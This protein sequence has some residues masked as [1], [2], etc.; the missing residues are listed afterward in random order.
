MCLQTNYL[1]ACGH[2]GGFDF[3]P[4]SRRDPPHRPA[5][6]CAILSLTKTKEAECQACAD[7]KTCKKLKDAK[8]L[9]EQTATTD[10]EPKTLDLLAESIETLAKA[11][12]EMI[13]ALHEVDEKTQTLN[14]MKTA[15][16][17]ESESESSEGG[18]VK[19]PAQL[20]EGKTAH[21]DESESES[22]EGGV[23]L[24]RQFAEGTFTVQ[25]ES[26]DDDSDGDMKL[27][28]N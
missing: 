20:A 16:Q 24:P 17:D 27:P 1:Y 15:Y 26:V 11:T 21:Q 6:Y 7:E 25:Q 4:C 10:T 19:L 18:G 28:G 2:D 9:A 14:E 8:N 22:E 5:L 23:K 3:R 13:K 12:D